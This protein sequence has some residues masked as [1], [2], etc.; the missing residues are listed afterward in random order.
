MS[1]PATLDFND[2]NKDFFPFNLLNE[3]SDLCSLDL[4][5]LRRGYNFFRAAGA[6]RFRGA[7]EG[8]GVHL[9]ALICRSGSIIAVPSF[10]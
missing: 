5:P 4:S 6:A 3:K 8:T 7:A 10:R 1:L 2:A 9:Q